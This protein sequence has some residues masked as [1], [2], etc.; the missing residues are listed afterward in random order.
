MAL[1]TQDL[2]QIKGL[3][4]EEVAA[5]LVEERVHTRAIVEEVVVREVGALSNQISN[6]IEHNF[7][8]AIDSLQEQIGEI[9]QDM[10]RMRVVVD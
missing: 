9:R 4:R 5:G 6:F 10:K 1:T 7:D 2:E 8:P 3:F